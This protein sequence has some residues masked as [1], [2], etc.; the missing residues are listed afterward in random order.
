MCRV[1]VAHDGL[2]ELRHRFLDTGQG[3]EL[4]VYLGKPVRAVLRDGRAGVGRGR[5][6]YGLSLMIANSTSPY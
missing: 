6:H 2:G 4:F 3:G 5:T 1:A